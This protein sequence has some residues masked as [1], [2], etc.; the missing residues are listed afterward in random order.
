[1]RPLGINDL[2]RI[3]N[4]FSIP[5]LDT[6]LHFLHSIIWLGAMFVSTTNV[7]TIDCLCA[8]L[9][10]DSA[11]CPSL[12]FHFALGTTLLHLFHRRALMPF[13]RSSRLTMYLIVLS[14]LSSIL[15]LGCCSIP[16]TI[17]PCIV[18]ISA[19]LPIDAIGFSSLLL[20][21]LPCSL[22]NSASSITSQTRKIRPVSIISCETPFR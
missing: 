6:G 4:P 3:R 5:T 17:L 9:P 19:G 2:V 11:L 18:F 1:V 13:M 15:C 21:S 20:H 14:L 10:G 22:P 7:A 12:S 8:S 16:P